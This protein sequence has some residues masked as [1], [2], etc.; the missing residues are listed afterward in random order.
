MEIVI[1]LI[2]S[3][4]IAYLGMLAMQMLVLAAGGSVSTGVNVLVLLSVFVLAAWVLGVYER[5]GWL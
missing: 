3:A 1:L 5:L 4:A 2:L